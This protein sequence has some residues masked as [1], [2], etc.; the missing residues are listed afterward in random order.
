M[1]MKCYSKR[2]PLYSGID[3]S[4][5]GLGAGILQ[6]REGVNCLCDEAPINTAVCLIGLTAKAYP[7]WKPDTV[8]LRRRYLVYPTDYR[9]FIITALLTISA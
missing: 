6:V 1:C 8:M 7:V 4:G 5:F 2:K 9:S 3:L